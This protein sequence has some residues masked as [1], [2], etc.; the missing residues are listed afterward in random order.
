MIGAFVALALVVV[1][2][3]IVSVGAATAARHQAQSAADLAAL[4]GAGA[5][6]GGAGCA[7]AAAAASRMD[8]VLEDC[9]VDEWDVQVRVRVPIALLRFGDRDA[10]ASARAGPVDG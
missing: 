4:A 6:M 2:A 3:L 5:L 1:T 8:A 9:I 7:E 10:V